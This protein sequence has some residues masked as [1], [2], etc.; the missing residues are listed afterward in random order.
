MLEKRSWCLLIFLFLPK[1][2]K[3]S[4]LFRELVNVFYLDYCR[5]FQQKKCG[6]FW[7][8]HTTLYLVQSFLQSLFSTRNKDSEINLKLK[9]IAK[10]NCS[11]KKLLI[12]SH[13]FRMENFC[14]EAGPSRVHLLWSLWHLPCMEIYHMHR[15]GDWVTQRSNAKI[16]RHSRFSPPRTF[17]EYEE[18][19]CKTFVGK[20]YKNSTG[21]ENYKLGVSEDVH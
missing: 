19:T 14:Y 2:F 7:T 21:R 18:K 5:I 9:L 17:Q 3:S 11:A 12:S 20:C 13:I 8:D 4:P 1:N 16:Q 6:L 15:S 10:W